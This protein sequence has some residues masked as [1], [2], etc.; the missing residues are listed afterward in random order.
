MG[1]NWLKI[2]WL[3]KDLRELTIYRA[4]C[5]SNVVKGLE[6]RRQNICQFG[7]KQ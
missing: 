2:I 7:P 4:C 5:Y 6:L 3:K 1:L